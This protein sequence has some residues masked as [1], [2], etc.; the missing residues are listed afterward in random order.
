MPAAAFEALDRRLD[1]ASSRPLAVA[2]SG[3]GD[4]LALLHVAK[5]WTDRAGRPLLALTVD[6]R[7]SPDSG[8]WTARAGAMAKARGVAWEELAWEEAKPAAGLPAAARDARHRLLA[9]AARRAGAGVLLFGHT[10]DDVRE[11]ALMRADTPALGVLR[12]WSPSPAWPQGRGV[13][14]LRPL[15]SVRRA[16]LRAWLAGQGA[17][18]LEDPANAD[19]RFARSRARAELAAADRGDPRPAPAEAELAPPPAG[20]SATDD[21]RLV[22]SRRDLI[23]ADPPMARRLAAVA[24]LCAAGGVR[25]PRSPALD[26]LLARIGDD[27]PFTASLA[28][29]RVIGDGPAVEFCREAG[30]LTRKPMA[31]LAL[32]PAE[33][34]V[35]DARFAIVAEEQ[36]MTAV[37]AAGGM[38]RLPPAEREA[39]RRL[40]AHARATLPL[41]IDAAGEASLPRPFGSG[42]ATASA[43][44]GAR[45][46]AACGLVRRE[47]DIAGAAVAKGGRSPY[48][49]TRPSE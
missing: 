42:S 40:P 37:A 17:V 49:E 48:L 47:A 36:S 35:F 43:L 24:L 15:L 44:A 7:L 41:L 4:S 19:P 33:A 25:P 3:G 20:C 9:E 31:P 8:A 27:R 2:F 45:F 12:E 21:G 22:L 38:A 14:L 5:A 26:R 32:S 23:E 6:H 30:E 39:L 18:W 28:G 11:S 13:F 46:D 10:A 34:R 1:P 29:A 16:T